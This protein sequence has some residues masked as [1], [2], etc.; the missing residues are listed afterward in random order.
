MPTP[1]ISGYRMPKNGE[2]ILRPGWI[3]PEKPCRKGHVKAR[4]KFNQCVECIREYRASKNH[5]KGVYA[6]WMNSNKEYRTKMRREYNKNNPEKRILAHAKQTAKRLGIPFDLEESDIIIPE[7]CP[8]F[9][10]TLIVHAASRRKENSASIDRIIPS[11]GYV[12]GN[13]VIISWRANRIK[14]DASLDEMKMLVKF[15]ERLTKN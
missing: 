1:R 5:Y 2:I 10:T 7:I 9:G 14:C 13:I 4:N 11:L 8:I 6:N 12:K 3:V 15:Y